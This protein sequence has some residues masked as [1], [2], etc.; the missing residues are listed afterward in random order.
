MS[1]KEAGTSLNVWN[2]DLPRHARPGL[3]VLRW[4]LDALVVD[5]LLELLELYTV[6]PPDDG[7]GF[8]FEP[9]RS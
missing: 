7:T 8:F 1:L 9:L 2:E 5:K 6:V 3:P 4:M